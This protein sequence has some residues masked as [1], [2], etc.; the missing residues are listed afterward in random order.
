MGKN[1]RATLQ[2]RG[3]KQNKRTG[4]VENQEGKRKKSILK[5]KKRGVKCKEE[6]KYMADVG[7]RERKKGKTRRK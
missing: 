5:R 4:G 1:G 2:W 3:A 7:M 6:D